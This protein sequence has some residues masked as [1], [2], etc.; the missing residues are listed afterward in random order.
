MPEAIARGI[1]LAEPPE[2]REDTPLK[3][4]FLVRSLDALRP[5]VLAHGGTLKAA[6]AAWAWRSALHLDG[7]DPEGNVLQFRCAAPA[8]A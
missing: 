1:T 5:V 2:P 8:K 3:T 7:T 4:S 6:G